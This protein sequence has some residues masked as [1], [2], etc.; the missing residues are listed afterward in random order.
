MQLSQFLDKEGHSLALTSGGV[1]WSNVARSGSAV[2]FRPFQCPV[3]SRLFEEQD[4]ADLM[5]EGFRWSI[6]D[7]PKTQHHPRKIED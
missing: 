4:A 1:A 2:T 3:S 7:L 5:L 6:G